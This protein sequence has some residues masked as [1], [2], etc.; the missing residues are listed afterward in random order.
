[1][2][3][4][5]ALLRI[6]LFAMLV[7]SLFQFNPA[8][9]VGVVLLG[10]VLLA[11]TN[12][13]DGKGIAFEGITATIIDIRGKAYSEIIEEILFQNS[14]LNDKLVAFEEGVKAETIFTEN[15]NLAVMQGYT[16]GEPDSH[17]ELGLFDALVTPK[18]VMFFMKF[19]PDSL[20]T[21]RFKTTMKAGAWNTASSEF[22]KVVLGN[23]ANAISVDAEF[24][25]WNAISTQ[26]A[27]AIAALVDGTDN[28]EIGEAEQVLAASLPTNTFV[29][30]GVIARMLYN[31]S[32]KDATP[33]VGGRIKVE[34]RIITV[35]NIADE[36]EKVYQ[37]IPDVVTADSN[38]IQPFIYAPY[39][40]KKMINTFNK[41]RQFRDIFDV[42][43]DKKKYY[44]NGVEIKFIPLPANVM[45]AARW[46]FICWCTDLLADIQKMEVNK[47]SPTQDMMFTKHVFTQAA[48]V[49]NQKY[50]VLYIG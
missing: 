32:N 9:T 31:N 30:D 34:G 27:A 48:H 16:A 24:K 28:D 22:E 6:A 10:A 18:K 19:N 14:T 5:S 38:P 11:C 37:A 39:N 23:Y 44:Y 36:Y 8:V 4:Q 1:M 20:R 25:F 2:K 29:L 43:D 45:I 21:S 47:V 41:N 42:S 26:T 35:E 50:N 46:D 49:M 17:G 7:A 40:H 15:E 3:R 12:F 13:G 33:G